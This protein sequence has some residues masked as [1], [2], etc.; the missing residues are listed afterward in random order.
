LNFSSTLS[1]L[2]VFS[3][4]LGIPRMGVGAEL[5]LVNANVFDGHAALGKAHIA[6]EHGRI[7]YVGADLG[8]VQCKETIDLQGKWVIPGLIDSHIHFF[9]SASLYT[10]PDIIDGRELMSYEEDQDYVRKY[11]PETFRRYLASGVTAVVDMGGPFWNFSV[12]EQ[13]LTTKGAPAVAVA[14]PLI[15]T[16]SRPQLDLGDPPIIQATSPAHATE[17]VNAQLKQNPDLIKVWFIVPEEGDLTQPLKIFDAV[18]AASHKAGV[19]VAVHATQY[20]AAT[21]CVEHGADILVHTVDDREVD[22]AFI[23]LLKTNDVTLVTTAVVYEGYAEVLGGS[24]ELSDIERALASPNALNSFAEFP[25]VVTTKTERERQAGRVTAMRAKLPTILKNI[26]TLWKGGVRVAAGSDAGNIGTFHG[27]SLHRELELLVE[28]GLSPAEAITAATANA[29]WVVRD[30][31]DFGRIGVGQRGDLLV[32]NA[33]PLEN[34]AHTTTI[35]AV[36]RNGVWHAGREL[37]SSTPEALVERQLQAYNKRDINGFIECYAEDVIIDSIVPGRP[38]MVGRK[39][40]QETYY[41]LFEKSPN[42]HARVTNRIVS[43]NFVIDHEL[44][45][46]LRA[47]PP[48]RAV[49]VYRVENGLIQQVWFIPKE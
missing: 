31:P 41:S 1:V 24:V 28:A 15:S 32:L 23:D 33:S 26:R 5:C 49:A 21:A 40:M 8:E 45:T 43:G 14:G 44:V 19:R 18:V 7:V 20:A 29:A 27:P 9:Q 17:L 37:F 48:V 30:K 11:L 34:I 2:L 47:G 6:L 42:L 46:G 39:A 25:F 35:Q 36:V 13:S 4:L 16:V 3:T 38:P 12:R 10:R 22:Q